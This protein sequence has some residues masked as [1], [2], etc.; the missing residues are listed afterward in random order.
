M[1]KRTIFFA[2]AFART[3][4]A[5]PNRSNNASSLRCDLR[6]SAFKK[7][8][9]KQANNSNYSPTNLRLL[10][11]IPRVATET[12]HLISI[13]N[14]GKIDSVNRI[15]II[16]AIYVVGVVAEHADRRNDTRDRARIAIDRLHSISTKVNQSTTNWPRSNSS[17]RSLRRSSTCI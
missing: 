9:H 16:A 12:E 7:S 17:W 1:K 10:V 2:L 4:G 6:I 11:G 5:M 13:E 8:K 15:Y 14:C 3:P